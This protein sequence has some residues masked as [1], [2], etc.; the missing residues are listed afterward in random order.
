MLK[1]KT[2]KSLKLLPVDFKANSSIFMRL[3]MAGMGQNKQE[4]LISLWPP[5]LE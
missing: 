2:N 4:C 1:L 5:K 3:E